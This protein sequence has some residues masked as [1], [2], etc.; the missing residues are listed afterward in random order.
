M[1]IWLVTGYFPRLVQRWQS[2]G[3]IKKKKKTV[4]GWA[5][6]WLIPAATRRNWGRPILSLSP[7]PPSTTLT[8]EQFNAV[9]DGRD[10]SARPSRQRRVLKSWVLVGAFGSL[11]LSLRRYFQP[12][13]L[14]LFHNDD[15]DEFYLSMRS[16][17]I[18]MAITFVI[19]AASI[20]AGSFFFPP[21]AHSCRLNSKWSRLLLFFVSNR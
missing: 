20:S 15:D 14:S 10:R 12:S 2:F 6:Y 3:K 4:I 9:L 17:F 8:N 1:L 11:S 13:I 7:P 21:F 18:S 19:T 5:S 16:A